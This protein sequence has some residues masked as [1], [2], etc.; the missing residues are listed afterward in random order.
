MSKNSGLNSYS[1]PVDADN[2]F[3]TLHRNDRGMLFKWTSPVSKINRFLIQE[4]HYFQKSN[5]EVLDKSKAL[6]EN[7]KL[8]RAC[9][10][11]II[12]IS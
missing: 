6:D 1:L 2:L 7:I 11:Y 12:N 3:T 10:T 9:K 4:K 5:N 8:P